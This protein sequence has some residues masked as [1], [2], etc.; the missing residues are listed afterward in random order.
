[1]AYPKGSEWRKWDLHIHTPCSIEQNYGG[2]T[3]ASWEKYLA[4]LERLPSS[5]KVLGI[6][7][8]IFIDGYRRVLEA[9]LRGRLPNIDLILPV[10]ELRID[11][12]S[13][14]EDALKRVNYHVIFSDEVE[15]DVIEAQFLSTL[16]SE[17]QLTPEY[18]E[19]GIRWSGVPTRASLTDLGSQI[20]ASM[21]ANKITPNSSPL[22]VGFHSLNLSIKGIQNALAS[23]Y[24]EG[25]VIE[26]VGKT[27]WD[28]IRWTGSIAEKKTLV[29]GVDLV[30]IAAADADLHA[31]ARKSLTDAK[32][33]DRLLDCS[34]A[35][36]FSSSPVK[37]RIGNSA[38]WMKA[39]PTFQGL[40]HVLKE[41]EDRVYI[42]QE[43]E[44]NRSVRARP[45]K[46]IRSLSISRVAGTSFEEP[47]FDGVSLQFNPGLVAVI[48]NKGSGKS[49]LVDILG[50]MGNA[51]H[52]ADASFLNTKRFNEPR[53]QK[54]SNFE[55]VLTWESGER[56]TR[57]LN[58]TPPTDEVERIKYI[59][60]HFF[61]K[62]CNELT[63]TKAG[64]FDREIQ[65][66]I[67]SHVPEAERLEQ[68]SLELLINRRTEEIG[69]ATSSLRDR[70][71]RLNRKIIALECDATAERYSQLLKQREAKQAEVEA[72]AKAKPAPVSQPGEGGDPAVQA[73][74]ARMQ[75]AKAELGRVELRIQEERDK[76]KALARQSAAAQ[77]S[78]EKIENLQEYIATFKEEIA[79]DLE[80][81]DIP[82]ESLF[83]ERLDISPLR[84][85]ATRLEEAKRVSEALINSR[86]EGELAQQK[87]AALGQ[88]S[89]GPNHIR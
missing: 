70:L 50:L 72:H 8:Y 59:P 80:E 83:F 19:Y 12:F 39:D 62:I 14:S 51:R 79:A 13:G 65:N 63:G 7:D 67:F 44:L 6:N 60:Q 87:V 15:P 1:M 28:Q 53:Q 86:D 40:C 43:P 3:P 16:S 89:F 78:R 31:K 69:R 30:F 81:L 20:I 25:K 5:F 54:G 45:T 23:T 76:Q 18:A 46:F 34:D 48:G 85:A 61:E 32:V 36:S 41:W 24:F 73:A 22:H 35:H 10:I 71:K 9:K 26:A 33:N 49:A 88:I 68:V 84:D 21:P 82:L 42:G 47:W 17:Y 57:R 64:E 74:N 27:E 29:N 4:D 77:R 66:V 38:T 55:A 11:K 75:A 58:V 37:D 52:Q 56:V 2:N